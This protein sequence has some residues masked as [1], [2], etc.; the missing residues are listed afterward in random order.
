MRPW[1]SSTP[2]LH[3]TSSWGPA[4]Q[5]LVTTTFW[6]LDS[7]CSAPPAGWTSFPG[8]PEQNSAL[9]LHWLLCLACLATLAAKSVLWSSSRHS[10]TA[11]HP[12]A[13]AWRSLCD[14]YH[15]PPPCELDRLPYPAATAGRLSKEATE[16]PCCSPPVTSSSLWPWDPH[17]LGPVPVLGLLGPVAEAS[18]RLPAPTDLLT[19]SALFCGLL[20]AWVYLH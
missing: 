1:Q 7:C 6:L 3:P 19:G 2:L 16:L 20:A 12:F 13:C 4:T 18:C 15:P 11:P 5:N 8:W 14:S 17:P 10:S 9:L